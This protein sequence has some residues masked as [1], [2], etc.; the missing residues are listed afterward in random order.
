MVVR[1]AGGGW[2]RVVIGCGAR[3]GEG[4]GKNPWRMGEKG[5]LSAAAV[6]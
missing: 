1:K 2:Q 5:G 3:A 6:T 4:R